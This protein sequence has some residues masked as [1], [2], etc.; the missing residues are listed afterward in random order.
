MFRRLVSLP[1]LGPALFAVAAL[2]IVAPT[3]T[4]RANASC[5]SESCPLDKASLWNESQLS[6][7]LSQ[8]YIDQDQPRVGTHDAAVGAIASHHD[9]VRTVNRI[10]TA[11]AA[12]R[13]S[14]AWAFSAALPFVNRTHEHIHN[15]L[16]VPEYQRWNYAH[17]GDLEAIALRRFTSGMDAKRTFFV[18]AGFKAPTG[19]TEVE[20][21]DGDQ[22]EPSARPGT[23]SWDVLAGLGAEWKLHGPSFGGGG[24]M[25]I[26]ASV[27]GRWNGRG[28]E[29]YQVG[30]ELTAYLGTEVPFARA[31]SL[32]FQT[33][34]RVRAKDDVGNF[35][36]EAGN[37]GGT[38]VYL[39]PGLKFAVGPHLSLYGLFQVPVYQRV[40][41][42]Q[43]VS[44]SNLY[45]GVSRAIL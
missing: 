1:L 17:V 21:V 39:S 18:T 8:Q 26:R 27:N 24:E 6:F 11:R 42:I 23:G 12:Y 25:P 33:N 35:D 14:D 15:H 43:V 13:P 44:D 4:P 31:A 30:G 28:T 37:T 40:N 29:N 7:E 41:G 36:A 32:L 16:G 38:A 5:G 22:P 3:L 10:S 20:E 34:L 2:A 19:V 9:E 45:F